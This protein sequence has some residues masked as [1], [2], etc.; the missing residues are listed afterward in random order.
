M[1]AHRAGKMGR[2]MLNSPMLR[3]PLAAVLTQV[4]LLDRTALP[5]QQQNDVTQL[6]RAVSKAAR[7]ASQLLTL[8]RAEPGERGSVVKR[9]L[10]LEPL[11]E[12]LVQEWVP[13]ADLHGWPKNP[14]KNDATVPIVADSIRRLGF[15]APILARRQN[16]QIVAG[17]TRASACDLLVKR[18]QKA[19]TRERQTW[20]PDAVRV[21]TRGEVVVRFVDLDEHDSTLLAL[22]DNRIGEHSAWDEE[23]LAGVLGDLGGDGVDLLDGTG[24]T[25]A[26]IKKLLDGDD[27][28]G[29]TGG[30][31]GEDRYRNQFGVIVVC[32]DEKEQARIYEQLRGEGYNCKVV[33]T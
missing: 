14:R 21:A 33:V 30:D 7:L 9:P 23:Q 17:H 20:H 26:D 11:C 8:A 13:R 2:R 18:W 16:H 5:S 25:D 6:H 28:S 24:F 19:T 29:A 22:A 1:G 27:G 32:A 10:D 15:G 3:T 12:E 31:P 4:E